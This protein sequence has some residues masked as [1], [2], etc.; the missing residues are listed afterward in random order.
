MRVV[1][2]LLAIVVIG[3]AIWFAHTRDVKDRQRA[4]HEAA[5]TPF[6]RDLPIGTS[7]AD[8]E[9]YL[10]SRGLKYSATW[11]SARRSW[12]DVVEVDKQASETGRCAKSTLVSLEFNS[13]GQSANDLPQPTDKLQHIYIE[14]PGP[15]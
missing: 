12:S 10:E 4:T 8:V 11:E 1:N 6:Q 5:V 13:S 2:V 15:C 14:S 3:V 7:R 9:K